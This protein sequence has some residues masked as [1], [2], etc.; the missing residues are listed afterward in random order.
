MHDA[1]VSSVTRSVRRA[2]GA[3]YARSWMKDI[4]EE[5]LEGATKE[6]E[7]RLCCPQVGM[8]SKFVRGGTLGWLW[9]IRRKLILASPH[10][11]K[12]ILR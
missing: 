2:L 3:D 8:G 6:I 5:Q 10:V 11:P 7:D 9:R 1:C 12:D 4:G